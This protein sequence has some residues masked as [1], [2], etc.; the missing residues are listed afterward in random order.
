MTSLYELNV[1]SRLFV[2]NFDQFMIV[3]FRI[4]PMSFSTTGSIAGIIN[5]IRFKSDRLTIF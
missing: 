2:D 4:Y 5:K 3:K 1:I